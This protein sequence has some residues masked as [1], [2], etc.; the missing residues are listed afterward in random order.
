MALRTLGRKAGHQTGGS[1]NPPCG[2]MALRTYGLTDDGRQM[3]KFQSALRINGPSNNVDAGLFEQALSSFN[4][5]CG[6]MALRTVAGRN[7]R[8]PDESFNPPCGSMAL[9]TTTRIVNH[10]DTGLF[11]SA[12]RINGPSNFDRNGV[13]SLHALVSIRLADQWPFERPQPARNP[14]QRECFN[15]P[16]GSMALRTSQAPRPRCT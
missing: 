8:T 2:S 6:S 7:R 11:Q 1:F 10:S 9:R 3:L 13:T 5:P 15:P 12:L 14:D 4:P 16:C